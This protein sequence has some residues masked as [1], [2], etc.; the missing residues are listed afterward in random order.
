MRCIIA[1]LALLLTPILARADDSGP[2]RDVGTVRSDARVLLAHTA[3]LAGVDPKQIVISDVAV[4]GDRANLSWNIGKERGLMRFVLSEN[5]WWGTLEESNYA[6]VPHTD[7]S[8]HPAGGLVHFPRSQTSGYDFSL[9]YSANNA[10]NNTNFA[11]VRTRPPTHAE[12]LPYPTPYRYVADAVM[13]FDFGVDGS[14]PVSFQRG[15]SVDVWFPFVLDDKLK[16]SIVFSAASTAVGPVTGT[17][18]DNVLHFDL[19]AFTA[20]P[21]EPFMGEID[22]DFR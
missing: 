9:R 20:T 22:G 15:S 16:Y 8:V 6:V 10:G 7:L 5:R 1:V 11:G 4:S 18:F 12:F 21:G 14:K 3:R 17:I 2:P 13:F 19:P